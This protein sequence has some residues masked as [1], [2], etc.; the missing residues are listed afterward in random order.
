MAGQ[1]KTAETGVQVGEESTLWRKLARIYVGTTVVAWPFTDLAMRFFVALPFLRSGYLKA[2]DWQTAVDLATY[3]YPV[4]WM[5]PQSA[6]A[7]GLAIELIAPL[8]LLLGFLT[9]PAAFAMAVLTIISQVVYIPTTTNLML[10]AMLTWYVIYGPASISL[11]HY[12]VRKSAT[13]SARIVKRLVAIGKWS[14]E[15]LPG[16]FLLAMRVWL[17]V[18][19]L[20]LAGEFEPSIALATWLPSTSFFGLPHWVAILF[21]ILLFSGTAASPVSYTLTF[22][23]AAFMIS[24]VHP[25]VTLYP[26]LLL[27]LY[28]ARG[29]GVLSVDQT[30]ERLLAKRF[31]SLNEAGV[32]PDDWLGTLREWRDDASSA[33]HAFRK[34]RAE[35]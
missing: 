9:R 32:D 26:V 25:S 7:T 21:A 29:A 1:A 27:G 8:L 5:A 17:G 19:L 10:I 2:S 14:R 4:N 30:V 35:S 23:V 13:V 11:D 18:S 28:D 3:E 22:V 31:P 20:A 15:N 6:A 33:F 16:I 24:G 12:W 34:R